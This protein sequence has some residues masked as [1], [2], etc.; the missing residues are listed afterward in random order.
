MKVFKWISI[1]LAAVVAGLLALQMVMYY[2]LTG[3]P[4]PLRHIESLTNPTDV[5]GWSAAG[6]RLADGRVVSLPGFKQI[7]AEIKALSAATAHGV[8]ID[9][10]G[11]SYGVLKIWH[12]CGNDPLR[13]DYR[14]GDLNQ[15]LAFERAGEPLDSTMP[16]DTRE[17][18]PGLGFTDHGW[19]VSSFAK[20]RHYYR[21]R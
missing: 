11:R 5:T 7:P 20:Y 3:S 17:K 2:F 21:R 18:T 12:W 16:F 13:T 9:P 19:S 15:L 4:W 14:R 8:E 1:S 6:L 10:N